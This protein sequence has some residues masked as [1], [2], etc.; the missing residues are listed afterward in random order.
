VKCATEPPTFSQSAAVLPFFDMADG[1]MSGVFDDWTFDD[2]FQFVDFAC[3][4][5]EDEGDSGPWRTDVPPGPGGIPGPV[6]PQVPQAPATS[7]MLFG[8]PAGAV[9]LGG[10]GNGEALRV[11]RT[12][13]A[14]PG[15]RSV[16]DVFM[17]MVGVPP[18]KEAL[19]SLRGLF[20]YTG[21]VTRSQ[22]RDRKEL[23]SSLEEYRAR[24]LAELEEPRVVEA[25]ASI[26]MK[27]NHRPPDQKEMLFNWHQ[28]R[29]GM[30]QCA[31]A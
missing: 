26:L 12:L 25:V 13:S 15:D 9:F 5:V 19:I 29:A 2:E 3:E 4:T 22:K 8:S 6:G 21:V 28:F 20:P 14:C 30:F 18:T 31:P 7:P 1:P 17:S 16:H 24:I 11:S 23:V 27:G 10:V